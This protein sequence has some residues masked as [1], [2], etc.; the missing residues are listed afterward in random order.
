MVYDSRGSRS[1]RL[2]T[3]LPSEAVGSSVDGRHVRCE[4]EFSKITVLGRSQYRVLE[5]IFN[6]GTTT[7]E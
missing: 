5:S 1:R 3:L 2:L 7:A 6:Q 4:Q